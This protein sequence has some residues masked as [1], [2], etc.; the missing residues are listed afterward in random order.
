MVAAREE[1]RTCVEELRLYH[2]R[3]IALRL[4]ARFDAADT[5]T[6]QS[7]AVW[8]AGELCG[9]YG[10]ALLVRCARHP[11]QN[12]RRLAASA[13]GKVVAGARVGSTARREALVQAREALV[14]LKADAVPQVRQYAEKALDEFPRPPA[15]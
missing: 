9:E 12:V 5:E 1:A 14:A 11:T 3:E 6:E 10:L 4:G 2:P 8:A 15:A 13:L 7:R